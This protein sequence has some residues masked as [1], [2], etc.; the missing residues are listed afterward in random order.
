[1]LQKAASDNSISGYPSLASK[2]PA[3]ECRVGWSNTRVDGSIVQKS[4]MSLPESST[5]PMESSPND[6][7]GALGVIDVSASSSAI[8]RSVSTIQNE[9]VIEFLHSLFA[10]G[11]GHA[12]GGLEA[13]ASEIARMTGGR[14]NIAW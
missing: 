13:V 6:I 9:G 3:I 1:M 12:G 5:I 7:S 14:A 2:N 8:S 11:K 10:Q 4:C